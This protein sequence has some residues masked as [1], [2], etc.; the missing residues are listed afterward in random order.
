M[1]DVQDV[2]KYRNSS[3]MTPSHYLYIFQTKVCFNI[4]WTILCY[5]NS[6]PRGLI[7]LTCIQ[8]KTYLSEL[9]QIQNIKRGKTQTKA[10]FTRPESWRYD[11]LQ[12][13]IAQTKNA[14]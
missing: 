8:I 14:M 4:K 5:D 11:C 1:R 12:S 13:V 10:I 6:I 9:Y 3:F 2:N 7:V